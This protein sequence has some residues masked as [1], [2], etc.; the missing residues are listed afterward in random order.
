MDSAISRLLTWR[1]TVAPISLSL[2]YTP[3]A[4]TRL[5]GGLDQCSLLLTLFSQ[6]N[7]AL[8]FLGISERGARSNGTSITNILIVAYIQW[9]LKKGPSRQF[10]KIKKRYE[11]AVC[12]Y[13]LR[14]HQ[15]KK[16]QASGFQSDQK[17]SLSASP[18]FF[19]SSFLLPNEN[20][21]RMQIPLKD[22]ETRISL[23]V[24]TTLMR[25]LKCN[26]CLSS[27]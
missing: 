21:I 14:G 5:K 16:L 19:L 4:S 2:V 10:K 24:L 1:L 8:F 27:S 6:R 22:Q 11:G 9:R 12:C 20:K 15:K 18:H 3:Q 13:V 25:E 7:N 26:P 23:R 17:S